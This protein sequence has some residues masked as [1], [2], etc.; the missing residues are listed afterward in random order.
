MNARTMSRRWKQLAALIALAGVVTFPTLA[1]AANVKC[2]YTTN[3]EEINDFPGDYTAIPSSGNI[4]LNLQQGDALWIACKNRVRKKKYKYMTLNITGQ[5]TGI[6]NVERFILQEIDGLLTPDDDSLPS[7]S[8]NIVLIEISTIESGGD[9]VGKKRKY[10]FRPQP[11]WERMKLIMSTDF[12]DETINVKASTVCEDKKKL[13]ELE[14]TEMRLRKANVG[15]PNAMEGTP[16]VTEL[17]LFPVTGSVDTGGT[18]SIVA[19]PA[20][21]SWTWSFETVDPSGD[22]RPG[23]GV[24]FST[25]GTGLTEDHEFDASIPLV[26]GAGPRYD[27][28]IYDTD[29]GEYEEFLVDHSEVSVPAVQNVSIIAGLLLLTGVAVLTLRRRMAMG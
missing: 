29:I 1:E 26:S 24:L 13:S 7:K 15:A 18:P 19:P 23:G 4:T 10:R 6:N 16:R 9:P 17:W 20:S 12:D 14:E 8:E 2:Y 25:T 5:L 21:G 28:F 11:D 22:S 27:L 3:G